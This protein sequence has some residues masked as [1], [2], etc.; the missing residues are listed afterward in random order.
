MTLKDCVATR[1]YATRC[2][3]SGSS[4]GIWTRPPARLR[5]GLL[6]FQTTLSISTGLSFLAPERIRFE[7]DWGNSR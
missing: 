3:T 4:N 6:R 7:I 5:F 1:L 2:W